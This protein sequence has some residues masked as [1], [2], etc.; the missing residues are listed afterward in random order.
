MAETVESLAD[1]QWR[2]RLAAFAD[3]LIPGGAGMPSA[4][5]A[6]VHKAG[7][8]R[9]LA[10]RPDLRELVTGVIGVDAEPC[11]ALNRLQ[12]EELGVFNRFAVT[13]AG[14]YFMN[15]N[16]RRLVGY[17]GDAPQRK[18]AKPGE[19][20]EYLKDGILDPVIERGPIYRPTP[21]RLAG[22]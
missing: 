18:R 10:C 16:V 3:A 2:Q 20:E 12:A 11:E 14:I 15:P 19:A 22:G 17:P 5:A 8:D 6:G 4:S 21:T 9:A 1:S 13:I 7:I